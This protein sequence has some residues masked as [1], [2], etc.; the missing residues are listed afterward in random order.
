M[1]Y[2]TAQVGNLVLKVEFDHDVESPRDWDGNLGKMVCWHR[3][4]NLGD[5]HRFDSPQE[6]K[7]EIH[8]RNAVILPLFLYDHSG[9]T[10]NTTGFSCRWDSGQV[11]YIYALKED[12]KREYGVK[13]VGKK[14]REM[15][16]K[17]LISEVDVYDSYIQ[18]NNYGFI[19]KD[20]NGIEVESCWG[21]IG[22]DFTTNGMKEAVPQEFQEIVAQF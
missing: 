15:I 17:R 7:Q 20:E 4:H 19:V 3:R 9:I 6:F 12:I 2:K 18:G 10:M 11:G 1:S 22:G 14:L 16:E 5:D 8:D 21:F 13:K